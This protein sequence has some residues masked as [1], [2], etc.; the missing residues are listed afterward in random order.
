M[1]PGLS[2]PE[3]N[4]TVTQFLSK[5]VFFGYKL[6]LTIHT[7]THKMIEQMAKYFLRYLIIKFFVTFIAK[8]STIVKIAL[9]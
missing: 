2:S 7:S 4:T 1:P 9:T 5:N 6:S 3:R 8:R